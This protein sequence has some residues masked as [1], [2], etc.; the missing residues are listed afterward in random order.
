[1]KT[2]FKF[3]VITSL[4]TMAS[5]SLGQTWT[6]VKIDPKA[7]Y[8]RDS[9]L[10]PMP[11]LTPIGFEHKGDFKIE[12]RTV[13]WF[14]RASDNK[15]SNN[16]SNEAVA[17]FAETDEVDTNWTNRNR[18]ATAIE[19]G[20]DFYTLPTWHGNNPTDIAEDFGVGSEIIRMDIPDNANWLFFT[21]YDNGFWNNEDDYSMPGADER[22]FGIE[23]RMVRPSAVPEPASLAAVGL[24]LLGLRRKRLAGRAH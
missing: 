14:N 11:T 3:S 15:S 5:M 2:W 9:Q 22:G 20:N 24:G 8:L 19:S 1:M 16:I 7:T 10:A 17:V 23:Y 21:P 12:I 13:G 18:I 4:V 6:F